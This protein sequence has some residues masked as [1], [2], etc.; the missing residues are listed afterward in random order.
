MTAAAGSAP[1]DRVLSFEGRVA[2]ITGAG[3]GLGRA[4]ATA[5]AARGA[6]VL[7]NDPATDD[8]E[9]LADRVCA[10][11]GADGG[12]A[13]PNYAS[14]ASREGGKAIVGDAVRRFGRIDILVNNAGIIRDRMFQNLPERDITDVIA[15]HLGGA[16]WVTQ[17]AWSVMRDQRYGRVVFTTSL[18]GLIGNPGQANYAAAKMGA[19]GLMKVLAAEGQRYGIAVN[20]IAPLAQTA[21]ASHLT[22]FDVTSF[23]PGQVASAVAYLAHESCTVNGEIISAIGGRVARYFIG[24]TPGVRFQELTPEDVAANIGQIVDA[25]GYFEPRTLDDEIGSV[26]SAE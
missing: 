13:F 20:A 8:G 26:A 11:I 15:V 22:A 14:V 18:S 4:Y 3:Q 23:T 17:P 19:V 21:M 7:V 5:L 2:V 6:A 10:E 24:L 1:G 9:A 16:F 12:K 25:R